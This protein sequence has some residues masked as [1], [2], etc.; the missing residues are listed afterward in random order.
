MKCLILA[1]GTSRFISTLTLGMREVS[2]GADGKARQSSGLPP[3]E[4]PN[5][6]CRGKTSIATQNIYKKQEDFSLTC[7]K[8]FRP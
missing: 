2:R 1:G 3:R 5:R 6:L 7:R 8:G 4:K